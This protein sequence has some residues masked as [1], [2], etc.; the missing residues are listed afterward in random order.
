MRKYEI[1][2]IIDASYS[3]E[4]IKA[5]NDKFT[6]FVEANNCTVD[7]VE[8][9][10]KKRLAYA[11]DKKTEGYYVLM[12]IVANPEFPAMIERQFRITDGILKFLV[13]NNEE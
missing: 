2:Y 7:S 13:V 5:L 4:Q 11:I 9:W 6:S 12:N 1:I 3:E 8:E 10:G